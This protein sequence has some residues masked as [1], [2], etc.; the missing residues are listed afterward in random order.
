MKIYF[1]SAALAAAL[2][3]CVTPNYV[4]PKGATAKLTIATNTLNTWNQQARV[5]EKADCADYPGKLVDLLQSKRVG[6]E[7]G[8]QTTTDI[9]SGTS[10]TVSVMAAVPRDD[11]F[12]SMFFKG[13]D[14]VAAE[15]RWCE[16]FATFRPE[17]GK[18]YRASYKI[19]G[20]PCSMQIMEIRNGQG[21]Q[22]TAAH[23]IDACSNVAKSKNNQMWTN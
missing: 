23:P 11:S 15:N 17:A 12:L 21:I 7:T 22:V 3:G 6:I 4:A 8:A 13:V 19:D 5:F 16:A 20:S 10:I 2:T 18:V 9:P 14:R 1:A